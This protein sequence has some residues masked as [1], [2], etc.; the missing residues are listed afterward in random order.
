MTAVKRIC[1]RGILLDNGSI[2][3]IGDIDY[4]V[5]Q[6]LVNSIGH[7]NLISWENIETAPGNNQIRLKSVG[8][9]PLNAEQR[10]TIDTGAKIEV[11]SSLE[12]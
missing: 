8:V 11:P 2:Q 7:D 3:T 4:V 1:D 5:S 10:I 12:K 6:Y 9:S